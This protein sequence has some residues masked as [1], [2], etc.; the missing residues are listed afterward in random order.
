MQFDYQQVLKPQDER[1]SIAMNMAEANCV[2]I[3]WIPAE[4]TPQ[5]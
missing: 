5:F 4:W 3:A 1:F 2:W